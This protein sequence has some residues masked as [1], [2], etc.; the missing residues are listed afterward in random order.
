MD[1]PRD[2]LPPLSRQGFVDLHL[3][4]TASDG[5]LPPAEVVNRARQAGLSA[6]ALTDHDTVAGIEA[7]RQTAGES[8]LEVVGGCEFSV[9]AP[10]G[11]MHALGL[12]LPVADDELLAFLEDRRADR[13]RRAATIV[14]RLKGLGVSV[15]LDQVES[16]AEG[17]ALGRPHVAR[18][19]VANGVVPDLNRAFARFLGWGRPAFVA[20]ELP[21]VAEVA[22]LVRRLGGVLVAAHLRGRGTE[23]NLL[24]LRDAGVQGIEV[25][26]PRHDGATRQRLM[27]LCNRY[28]LV[29]SGGSDWHGDDDTPTRETIGS[30][31]VPAEW[32]DDLEQRRNRRRP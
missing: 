32:L 5:V 20:K 7:A 6:I 23:E 12:F 11:E 27:T 2:G 21:E 29:P 15:T 24:V 16:L 3:H 17:A 4:S 9:L 13:H 18:A 10:W 30:Q 31:Q 19:L 1:V 14:D 25:R 22:R 28:G 26:H 8:G